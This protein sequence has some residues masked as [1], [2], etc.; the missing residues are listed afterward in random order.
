MEL[1]RADVR[2]EPARDATAA[3]FSDKDLLDAPPAIA[4]GFGVAACATVVPSRPAAHERAPAVAQAL[5]QHLRRTRTI[6]ARVARGLSL[7]FVALEPVTHR[8]G[9]DFTACGDLADG[10]P[11]LDEI[12]KRLTRNAAARRVA[13]R[14]LRCEAVLVHPVR[15]GRWRA[16]G[17]AGDRLDRATFGEL[18]G[19][20]GMVHDDTNT[21][22]CRGRNRGNN[23]PVSASA[24]A[25]AEARFR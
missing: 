11:L 4:D 19:E 21:S 10:Q 20:Q 25:P 24:G 7:Q 12:C 2:V 6:A 3:S 15:D 22:S 5:P 16:A 1:Q 17:L 8:R 13:L 9:A 23:R 14:V 18:G